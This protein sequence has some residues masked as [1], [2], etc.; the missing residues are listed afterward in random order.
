MLTIINE[1]L[2]KNGSDRIDVP[3]KSLIA[4]S[5]EIPEENQGLEALYDRFIVRMLVPPIQ[6]NATFNQ[7]LNSK[8]SA[9]KLYLDQDLIIS[10]HEMQQWR[11]QIQEVQ[12]SEE[13]L[14][15]I[16]QIRQRLNQ[17][18]QEKKKK[19][20]KQRKARQK[21]LP[22]KKTQ[23]KRKKKLHLSMYLTAVGNEP[24]CY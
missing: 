2:F 3:L 21:L 1:H 13:T 12:L 14:E 15:A 20:L 5:N 8:P 17:A 23:K 7:L 4:A 6:N 22:L 19:R 9:E 11:Q 24:Q 16:Q 10:N 18:E